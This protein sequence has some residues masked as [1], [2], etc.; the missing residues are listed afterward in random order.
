MRHII[1]CYKIKRYFLGKSL[2]KNLIINY[3]ITENVSVNCPHLNINKYFIV[4]LM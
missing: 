3:F 2:M 4:Q 1:L